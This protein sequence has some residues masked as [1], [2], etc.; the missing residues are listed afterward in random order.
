MQYGEKFGRAILQGIH[1]YNFEETLQ[2]LLL[3]NRAFL[4]VVCFTLCHSLRFIAQ[5]LDL[6]ERSYIFSYDLFQLCTSVGSSDATLLGRYR[7]LFL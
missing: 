1:K 3:L 5:H 2:F 6:I 4:K 7:Q